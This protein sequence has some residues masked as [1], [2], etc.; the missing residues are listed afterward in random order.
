M[1]SISHPK[2]DP[3]RAIW[4]ELLCASRKPNTSKYTRESIRPTGSFSLEDVDRTIEA[5][6]KHSIEK[7]HPYRTIEG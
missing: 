4:P 7:I 5:R 3:V 6:K 1:S 2:H